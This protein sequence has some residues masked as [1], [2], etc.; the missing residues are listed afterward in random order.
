MPWPSARFAALAAGETRAAGRSSLELTLADAATHVVA[1]EV[2][3]LTDLPAFDTAAMDGWAVMGPA[4]WRLVGSAAAGTDAQ[5]L[6]PGRALRISTGAVVPRDAAVLRLERGAERDGEVRVAAGEDEPRPGTDIRARGEEVRRGEVVLRPGTVLTPPAL[7]LAAAAG[8][9]VLPVVPKPTVTLVVLGDELVDSGVPA[10][11]RVRDALSPQLPGW[12]A[13][14]H[15]VLAAAVRVEDD[16]R[17][18]IDALDSA[19]TDLVVTTGGTARGQADHVLAALDRLGGRWLVNGVA[20]RPGHPMKLADL[21]DGRLWLAL[22]GNPLAAVSALISL[23]EPI[24]AVLS[25]R[26]PPRSVGSKGTPDVR[27]PLAEPL[28]SSPGAHRLIPATIRQGRVVPALR[29]GP[30]MLTGLASADV[31][32]V[33]PPGPNPLEPGTDVS[34]L[35]LPWGSGLVV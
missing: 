24:L 14:L 21:P 6:S 30:A 32:A 20:V 31:L 2:R 35:P 34:V 12:I 3:S 25:G 17:A 1:S 29:R 15:G 16:L 5:L 18:T 28:E 26:V 4:P 8:L 11:G 22:P 9:D 23:G 10:T 7:G 13:A 19:A 33:V 27:R